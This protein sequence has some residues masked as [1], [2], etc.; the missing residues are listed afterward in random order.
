[1]NRFLSKFS[2]IWQEH[3]A[4]CQGSPVPGDLSSLVR[5]KIRER[6]VARKNGFESFFPPPH[7]AG[8]QFYNSVQDLS[9]FE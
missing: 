2:R 1:M 9:G 6:A 5:A 4:S 7:F 3:R 8:I